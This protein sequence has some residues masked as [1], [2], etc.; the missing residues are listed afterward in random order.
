LTATLTPNSALQGTQNLSVVAT[1]TS[2]GTAAAVTQVSFTPAGAITVVGPVVHYPGQPIV[3]FII[4]ISPTATP[5]AYNFTATLATGGIVQGP[6]AFTVIALPPV[7]VS[8]SPPTGQQG[9]TLAVTAT[10]SRSVGT[11]SQV[12]FLPAGA[13]QVRD[14]APVPGATAVSFNIDIASSAP[15]GPYTFTYTLAA[16]GTTQVP[17]AFTVLPA[18]PVNVVLS[19]GVGQPGQSVRVAATFSSA[20]AA[21]RATGFSF[22]PAGALAV[23]DIRASGNSPVVPFVVDIAPTAA[24]GGYNLIVTFSSGAPVQIANA[25]T[26]TYTERVIGPRI[27]LVRPSQVRPGERYQLEFLGKNLTPGMR[28]DFGPGI[29]V[30]GAPIVVS[31]TQAS[32]QVVVSPSAAPGVRAAAATSAEGSNTG[33]G[34]V[35]VLSLGFAPDAGQP[36]APVAKKKQV[37]R[38]ER[39]KILNPLD[40]DSAH[41]V[42]SS[43]HSCEP[44]HLL[45][46]GVFSWEEE[47]RGLAESWSV[48]LVDCSGKVL[49][50]AQTSKPEFQVTAAWLSSLPAIDRDIES[51]QSACTIHKLASRLRASLANATAVQR[52][53]P[54]FRSATSGLGNYSSQHVAVYQMPPPATKSGGSTGAVTPTTK[55]AASSAAQN[56]LIAIPFFDGIEDWKKTAGLVVWRVKGFAPERYEDG[57]FTGERVQVEESD[58]N[59]IVLPL[60]PSGILDCGKAPGVSS[61]SVEPRSPASKN[62][63]T[64]QN[65]CGN[66]SFVCAGE[67]QF[68]VINGTLDLSRVP[69]DIGLPGFPSSKAAGHGMAINARTVRSTS[70]KGDGGPQ[71][72]PLKSVFVDWGD[73]SEP[74]PLVVQW[75]S[76]PDWRHIKVSSSMQHAY[77]YPS[78]DAPYK[79]RIYAQSDPD[80]AH[81]VG[82]ASATSSLHLVASARN[83]QAPAARQAAPSSGS[84]RLSA[85]SVA[86]STAPASPRAPAM[87]AQAATAALRSIESITFLLACA[88][89]TVYAAPGEGSQ[90]PLH[91]LKAEIVWPAPFQS[92]G[93]PEVSECSQA[94]RPKLRIYYWGHGKAKVAWFLDGDKMPLEDTELSGELPGISKKDGEAGTRPFEVSMANSVPVPLSGSPHT[95]VAKVTSMPAPPAPS[96]PG[97]SG[98]LHLAPALHSFREVG[99]RVALASSSSAPPSSASSS[100]SRLLQTNARAIESV[101]QLVDAPQPPSEIQAPPRQYAVRARKSGEACELRYRTSV[102]DFVISDVTDLKQTSGKYAGKGVLHLLFPSGRSA[103][104]AEFVPIDFSGWTID[105]SG[106][107]SW[108]VTDGVADTNAATSITPLDFEV[109]VSAVHLRPSQVTVDGSIGIG[110]GQGVPVPYGFKLPTWP[111]S[112]IPVL[113]SGDLYAEISR[114]VKIPLGYS[115]FQLALSKVVIDFSRTRGQS[116]ST[117]DCDTGDSGAAWTGLLAFGVLQAPDFSFRKGQK[118]LPD[119]PFDRW[120]FGPGGF[121]GDYHKDLNASLSAG[122]VKLHAGQFD[123]A[124]CNTS[125]ATKVAV[126]LS[127]VPLVEEPFAGVLQITTDRGILADFRGVAMHRD[128]RVVELNIGQAIFHYDSQVGDWDVQIDANAKL[129]LPNGT[130]VYEHEFAGFTVTLD[131]NLHTPGNRGDWIPAGDSGSGDL[132]G[133]PVQVTQLGVGARQNGGLWFGIS[134]Q[135]R[136]SDVFEAKAD[137]V[138]FELDRRGNSYAMAGVN[139]GDLR[140]DL[141]MPTVHAMADISWNMEG[142]RTMFAGSG[143]LDV[144]SSGLGI[145]ADFVYGTD[146][147]RSYWLAKGSV[148]LGAAAIPIAPPI[149]I[150]FYGFRGGIA[151]NV[152][153]NTFDGPA[154]NVRPKFDGSYIVQAGVYLGTYPDRGFYF[155]GAGDLKIQLGGSFGV[156]LDVD[157]WFLTADHSGDP[158]AHGCFQYANQAFDAGVKLDF[159]LAGGIIRVEAPSGGNVCTDSAISIHFGGDGWHLWFGTKQRPIHTTVL[160][161]TSD[162]WFTADNTGLITAGVSTGVDKKFC[163][164]FK[165]CDAC[166]WFRE[167]TL[168]EVRVTVQ[169][170]FSAWGHFHGG[171]GGGVTVCGKGLGF[172]GDLDLTAQAPNPVRICGDV[173]IT[174]HTPW[175]LPDAHIGFGV[176]V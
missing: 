11:V 148:E 130:K 54:L 30:L 4:N 175:P 23:R 154:R 39:V 34:G 84:A 159:Q 157:A 16:G 15:L 100:P 136:V 21:S 37:P 68:A 132:G 141:R 80:A 75:V 165:V 53:T 70:G 145:R 51:R 65:P 104:K 82:T 156:R 119:V 20:E 171:V 17:G 114:P 83:L 56:A 123:F 164:D 92:A 47:V 46:D 167:T 72:L 122:P 64:T 115:G 105:T 150:A 33:P 176:C 1:F 41:C 113:P 174:V 86:L 59:G 140:I 52:N 50:S 109:T 49:A 2:A 71:D 24:A 55:G 163:A 121:S 161:V 124:V 117:P 107:A 129:K 143:E 146:A 99:T 95:L 169:P 131:G 25:F 48:E 91:L 44:P 94:L 76:N 133:F 144:L 168:I 42:A 40:P 79:I 137:Q 32:L 22:T 116:P 18:P 6:N 35:E 120:A 170:S 63:P 97:A 142:S 9:Q 162:G 31:P 155:Y 7:T 58:E 149:P 78:G 36:P 87:T 110:P 14:L 60:P 5:A 139:V 62:A 66:P 98:V 74:E 61:I 13:I 151:H 172:D 147:G 96:P 8:L 45:A 88:D 101:L 166:A 89:A 29:D 43:T 85:A 153:L 118:L 152:D 112:G 127:G 67:N 69:F 138:R 38:M 125:F 81:P 134:G 19:P 77:R 160:F 90:D 26:V 126:D 28:V 111:F 158:S 108:T 73:R 3:G 135:V 173:H 57:T 106:G 12:A 10:F 27:D 128:Y 102:G 93:T 103:T